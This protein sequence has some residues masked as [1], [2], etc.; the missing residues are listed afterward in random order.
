MAG[1][2]ETGFVT[3]RLGEIITGLKENA[4]PIFQ[5]LVPPGDEVDTGDN[6]TIGRFAGLVSLSLDDLWQAGHS[7]YMSFDINSATGVALD[8][9]VEI[10]GIVRQ[11]QQN[12]TVDLYLF[13][14]VGT[15][16]NIG[17]AARSAVT[18]ATYL[19][20][21]PITFSPDRT[22][23]VGI[24][25]RNLRANTQYTLSYRK[26]S[27]EPY[28]DIVVTTNDFPSILYLQEAFATA[29]SSSHPEL[30]TEIRDETLIVRSASDFEIHDFSVSDDLLIT[31]AYGITLATASEPGSFEEAP[32]DVNIVSTPVWGWEAVTNPLSSIPGRL[33]ETDAELRERFK[34]SRFDRATN[35]IE[36]LYSALIVLFGVQNVIIYEN[37]TNVVDDKGLPP[38]SFLVIADGGSPVEI[39]RAIWQN[40]PT[41]ITSVGNTSV[42][43]VD[44]FGYTRTINFSRPVE[45][46]VYIQIELTTNNNFPADGEQQI[47]QALIEYVNQQKIQ[48]GIVYSRLYTPINSVPGHQV[49]SL[50][51]GTDP[52]NLNTQNISLSFDEIAKTSDVRITFI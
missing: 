11:E 48:T 50:L 2:T 7:I 46:P 41:G 5:D 19:T 22:Y 18:N 33:R 51:I 35:I 24:E 34:N 23:G 38:H 32:G 49:D 8:N 25:V 43:I 20:Q 28:T 44:A 14:R 26:G 29:I 45:V 1:V 17:A 52:D 21:N 6:S 40:R 39:A 15:T 13:G 12:T 16:T 30:T 42:D 27:P 36:A 47:K 37:D 31:Y 9:L 4:K 10:G 3:K